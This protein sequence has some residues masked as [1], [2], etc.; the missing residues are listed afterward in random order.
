VEILINLFSLLVLLGVGYG[1]GM[2]LERRHFASIREREQRLRAHPVITFDASPF[3]DLPKPPDL[4]NKIVAAD[5][6]GHDAR[7]VMGSTV[8]SLD[9]FKRFIA[10]LRGIF[11]GRIAAYESL[12]DRGRRESLLR[13][14]EEA[15]ASGFDA[16]INV[17]LETSTLARANS[18]GKGVAGVEVLAF[19]TAVKRP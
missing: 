1:I 14:R 17:R 16:V 15:I 19:G 5:G 8:V 4:S 7:M 12:L 18:N 13:M 10:G 6:S 3:P 9:Y 2:H 11:G